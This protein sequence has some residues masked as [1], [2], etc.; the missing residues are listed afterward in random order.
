MEGLHVIGEDEEE[1][2]EAKEV[3][4]APRK[5]RFEDE[6]SLQKEER[7]MEKTEEQSPPH[8]DLTTQKP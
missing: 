5:I 6:K 7:S 1:G 4:L 8:P 2:M 3:K